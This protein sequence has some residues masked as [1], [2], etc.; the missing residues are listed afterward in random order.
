MNWLTNIATGLKSLLEKKRVERELD[1]E[2]ES[3]VENSAAHK[4]SS[5]MSA[6]AA[7]RA[8]LAEVGSRN[9]V[10]HQVWSSRWE[11]TLE[12]LGKDIRVSLRMLGR[13][14]GFTVVALL[15]LALGIG[16][17]TAIFTLLDAIM[18]RPLPVQDPERLVL[19]GHAKAVGSTDGLPNES[20]DLYSYPTYRAFSQK[21]TSFSGVTA[22]CSIQ[23]ATH[24]LV[25]GGSGNEAGGAGGLELLH[26]D[27]VSGSYFSVLGVMPAMGRTLT[28]SADPDSQ[29]GG[30]DAVAVASYTWWQHHFGNDFSALGKPIKIEG[31]EYTIVGVA[32]P[33]F[34]G[35][36]VG[37]PADFWVPLS[38]QKEISP[39]WNGLDNKT[40]QSLFLIARLKP[41]VTA[42]QASS[43]TNVLFK[44]ILRADFVGPNP[45]T[46]ELERIQHALIEL[47]PMT[48]GIS[49]LRRRFALPL[50]I[51]MAIVAMVLLIACA[52]IAN[53]LLAR[54]AVRTRE[55]AVRMAMGASRR[56][57]IVQ[58]LTESALLAFAGAALGILFAW[59]ATHVLLAMAS[60]GV[61]PIPLDLS[62]DVRVLGFTVLLTMTTALFFGM[63][64]AL[65]ASRVELTP[66][67]K[68]G[69]GS[70]A[71]PTRNTLSHALIVGQIALSLLLL[72]GAGL[73]LRSLVNL[74]HV[75]TGFNS[76]DVTI[77]FLDESG[78]NLPQDARLILLQKQIEERVQALPGVQAASFSMFTFDEGEWSDP[79]TV[80]GIPRTPENSHDVLYN[81]VGDG[82]FSTMGLPIVAGRGFTARDNASDKSPLVAVINETM[83]RRF[84]PNGS[85]V[86]H[87]F[88]LG[89]DLSHSGDIEIVGVA[90]DAKYVSLDEGP[91][92]AAYFP[93]AQH[94]QYFSNFS[95]RSSIGA[96]QL[97][98]AVEKS[99][100]QVNANIV[101]GHV[102]TLR[103]Q[104]MGSLAKQ[105]LI[106]QLSA[107]FGL[108]AVFLAC[109]GIYGVISYAVA[110]RTNE[111]G[112]RIALGAQATAVQ[113]MVL[114]ELLVLLS[115][116]VA[117]GLP[118]TLVVTGLIKTQLFGLSA[119]DP[120][121]YVAA[122]AAVG[123]MSLLAAWPPAR[124]ATKVDPMVA[125]RCD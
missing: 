74:G 47:T 45:S 23:F 44:Q 16:G 97:I 99:I 30:S 120:A 33:G 96:G 4:Q 18:L 94:V 20:W 50:E 3:Y 60:G 92:M 72:A 109:I 77:F 61:G 51:L 11:S 116:G 90:K 13:S 75:D 41:G 19:F 71:A 52:N 43:E 102:S 22:V 108:L 36:T 117:V 93:Y 87:R 79:V 119:V 103:E 63:I 107:F 58:L 59:K 55:I 21:T 38:M 6:E 40:F 118:L 82:F 69:R 5:G 27:L 37:Q 8:A 85:A 83:Q 105:R 17:N 14:P 31:H 7:R 9:A 112:I 28:E 70:V 10:K 62:P 12:G 113:W 115:I 73:F 95:V 49:R 121:T 91:E 26:V 101:V 111:I 42:A 24:A 54:G 64:P 123:A 2:L 78:V 106:S 67:L 32:Q 76:H 39:G 66:A 80:Q 57:I 100:A 84:F 1:E 34:T 68:E 98:P 88:G 46:N 122:I 114:R 124:R 56:R 25:N 15:S 65:R 110:R 35:A 89:D 48:T 104:V 125:L 29:P 86:G 53:M 81:S